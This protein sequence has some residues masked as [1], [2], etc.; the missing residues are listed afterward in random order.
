[1]RNVAINVE[2]LK[3]TIRDNHLTSQSLAKIVGISPHDLYNGYKGNGIQYDKLSMIAKKLGKPVEYFL[4][5][6]V[7][8]IER[9]NAKPTRV[10]S[11]PYDPKLYRMILDL[12]EKTL[13]ARGFD[14]TPEK[15]KDLHSR[16]YNVAIDKENINEDFLDG[17]IRSTIE[18][19]M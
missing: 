5:D 4:G 11:K 6:N 18:Y 10:S 2:K 8:Y 3:S 14:I 15:I 16:I 1:M 9:S 17:V 13:T 19:Y 12:I 7:K